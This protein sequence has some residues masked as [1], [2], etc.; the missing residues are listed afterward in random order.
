M[1]SS[2]G[3]GCSLETRCNSRSAE[4]THTAP[5]NLDDHWTLDNLMI[6]KPSWNTYAKRTRSTLSPSRRVHQVCRKQSIV[7]R[8]P[9]RRHMRIMPS[10]LQTI[11]AFYKYIWVLQTT[12]ALFRSL[13]MAAKLLMP[14]LALAS[15]SASHQHASRSFVCCIK[16]DREKSSQQSWTLWP[17]SLLTE[18]KVHSNQL[19]EYMSL[20]RAWCG[21]PARLIICRM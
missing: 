20:M 5:S 7:N 9:E 4:S 21:H 18:K 2:G 10:I 16:T 3:I 17:P 14:K 8:L 15:T 12:S 13:L 1:L 6:L 11:W 19:G